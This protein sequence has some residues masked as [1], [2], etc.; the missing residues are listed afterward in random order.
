MSSSSVWYPC[1][2][3]TPLRHTTWLTCPKT[4]FLTQSDLFAFVPRRGDTQ[5]LLSNYRRLAKRDFRIDLA[6]GLVQLPARPTPTKHPTVERI[7]F[8]L[9]GRCPSKSKISPPPAALS[10]PALLPSCLLPPTSAY[11][12][13]TVTF[14]LSVSPQSLP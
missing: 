9:F 12:L 2:C 1:R 11:A 10:L 13:T 6:T 8:T 4:H 3:P 14:Q 5:L 7:F